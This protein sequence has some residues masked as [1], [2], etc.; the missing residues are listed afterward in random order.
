MALALVGWR[1]C[2]LYSCFVLLCV[3]LLCCVLL[4]LCFALL[5]SSVA[6]LCPA[7]SYFL[8]AAVVFCD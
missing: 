3:A 2:S 8:M 4:L 6:L 1:F 5:R 7:L